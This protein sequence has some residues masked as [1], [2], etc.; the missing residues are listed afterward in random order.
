MPLMLWGQQASWGAR[1]SAMTTYLSAAA[2]AG[3]DQP[4]YVNRP[5]RDGVMVAED[6][7]TCAPAFTRERAATIML[8]DLREQD[9]R[10]PQR[11]YLRYGLSYRDVEEFSIEK[12]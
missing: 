2:A 9:S 1:A 4:E 10:H 7:E 3:A 12:T 6:P 8:P 11:C 5:R